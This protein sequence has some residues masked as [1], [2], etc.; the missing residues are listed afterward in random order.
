MSEHG[1]PVTATLT[2]PGLREL[3]ATEVG[4]DPEQ[5][6]QHPEIALEN[7]GLDSIAQVEL[8]VVL[9]QRHGVS[10]LPEDVSEMSFD[11]LAAYLCGAA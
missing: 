3:L 10:E 9:Q 4:I 6:T 7:L 2:P 8:S 11:E 1:K 5:L